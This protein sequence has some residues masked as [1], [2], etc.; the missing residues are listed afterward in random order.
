[1]HLNNIFKH[2]SAVAI[3]GNAPSNIHNPTTQIQKAPLPEGDN[4]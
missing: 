2:E 3:G 1:M 4:A